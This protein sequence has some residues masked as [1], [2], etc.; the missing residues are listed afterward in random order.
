MS[1]L[2]THCYGHSINL[3][4][5]DAIKLSERFKMALEVTHEITKLVKYFP[6]CDELFK[7]QK[8]AHDHATQHVSPGVRV[9]CGLFAHAN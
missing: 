1:T 2:Y 7:Y 3:A 4:V 8:T 9:L 5:N 6:R